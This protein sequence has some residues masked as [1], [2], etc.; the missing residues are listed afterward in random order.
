[1]KSCSVG[2]A[3]PT[4]Y[5]DSKE[6]NKVCCLQVNMPVYLVQRP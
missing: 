2:E 3:C 4:I 1:M 5:V 6:D